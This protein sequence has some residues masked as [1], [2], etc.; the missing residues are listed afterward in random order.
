[1][2]AQ[3][4]DLVWAVVEQLLLL[5]RVG[6]P[7]SVVTAH[8]ILLVHIQRD[9]PEVLQVAI[10]KDRSCLCCSDSFVWKFIYAQLHWVPRASTQTAKTVPDD[11][12]QR[13]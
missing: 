13:M 8:A 10:A 9:A 3:Y 2:Q 11:A 5:C 4:P 7:V 12:E 1:M 6:V